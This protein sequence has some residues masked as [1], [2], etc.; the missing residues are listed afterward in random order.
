[1]ATKNSQIA[2]EA[3]HAKVKIEAEKKSLKIAG[4]EIWALG[5]QTE[6]HMA[7][8]LEDLKWL[9]S[10]APQNFNRFNQTQKERLTALINHIKALSV[11]LRTEVAL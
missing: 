1:M 3:I 8:C 6:K 10:E 11:L 4:H 2:D 9:Q 7:G 5:S